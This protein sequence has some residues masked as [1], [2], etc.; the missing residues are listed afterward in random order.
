MQMKALWYC[1]SQH[2]AFWILKKQQSDFLFY[3]FLIGIVFEECA[4]TVIDEIESWVVDTVL[5]VCSE[6]AFVVPSD[7]RYSDFFFVRG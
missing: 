5:R 1:T 6:H 4:H 2:D 7:C 3:C